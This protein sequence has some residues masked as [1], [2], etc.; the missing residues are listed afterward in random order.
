MSNGHILGFVVSLAMTLAAC[1]PLPREIPLEPAEQHTV[2]NASVAVTRQLTPGFIFTTPSKALV[3]AGMF[4]WKDPDQALTWGL[5]TRT[6]GVPDFTETM[7]NVFVQAVEGRQLVRSNRTETWQQTDDFSYLVGH[8]QTDYVLE[9]RT[10]NGIFGYKPLAWKTYQMN[11]FGEALLIRMS[12]LTAVWKASCAAR[13]EDD[14][15]LT[16]PGSDFLAGDGELFRAAAAYATRTCG[17]QLANAY[18]GIF[19]D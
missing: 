18:L 12:D 11:Y 3:D 19:S 13:A 9:L 17:E 7:L 4:R 1:A 2:R 15:P 14:N 6:H 5:M 8:Y 10:M 16:L